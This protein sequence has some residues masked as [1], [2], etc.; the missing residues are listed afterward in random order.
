MVGK[1]TNT[2]Y[3]LCIRRIYNYVSVDGILLILLQNGFLQLNDVLLTYCSD[4][5]N[6]LFDS[7]ITA[8]Y[9]QKIVPRGAVP[10]Y[11]CGS[12]SRSGEVLPLPPVGQ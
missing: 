12:T 4:D 11:M 2:L 1:G 6:N 7:H 9:F 5:R 10:C 3:V 8:D